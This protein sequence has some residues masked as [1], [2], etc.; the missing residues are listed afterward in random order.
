MLYIGPALGVGT[1]ILIVLILL[2][3]LFSFGYRLWFFFSNITSTTTKTNREKKSGVKIFGLSFY[4]A[5]LVSFMIIFTLDPELFGKEYD[6]YYGKKIL[7]LPI[8]VTILVFLLIIGAF[9]FTIYTLHKRRVERL[10]TATSKEETESYRFS[11]LHVVV[12]L[13]IVLWYVQTIIG[14]WVISLG[15]ISVSSLLLGLFAGIL[16]GQGLIWL[17]PLFFDTAKNSLRLLN[18]LV[19]PKN[20]PD[21]LEILNSA[22]NKTLGNLFSLTFYMAVIFYDAYVLSY[23]LFSESSS[24]SYSII[25]VLV[26][27]SVGTILP[28]LRRKKRSSAYSDFSQLFHH[29]ILDNYHVGKTLLKRQIKRTKHP[30]KEGV[31]SAVLVTGLARSGT[32]ALTRLLNERGPFRSLDYSNMPVLLA[33]R[34]WARFY[35]PNREEKEERA[36]GDGIKV[37]LASVEALEEYFFK[38]I[39]DDRFITE[40]RLLRHDLSVSENELYRKYFKSLCKP[41]ELYLAKNNNAILRLPSLTKLNPDLRVFILIRDPLE[42]AYSLHG[43]HQ[44]FLQQQEK[45]PFILTYMNWLGHHEFGKGQLP[46]DLGALGDDRDREKLDFWLERWIEYYSYAKNLEGVQFIRYEEFLAHPSQVVERIAKVT[47]MTIN[48][49]NI[50]VFEKTPEAPRGFSPDLALKAQ[51]VYEGLG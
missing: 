51:K 5:L 27:L 35:R 6:G 10:N 13:S 42:H 41:G 33:P 44:N 14:M 38:V 16:L 48:A 25:W 32:T 19:A 39:K 28:F 24:Q 11:P 2:L 18:Q 40:D 45:D 43:Q 29:I 30:V 12:L 1:G 7:G 31:V 17:K 36:H 4:L 37:G 22:T 3:I 26:A 9:T 23:G 47:G 50:P 15:S 21:K 8:W 46:F 49:E 34:L 20:A